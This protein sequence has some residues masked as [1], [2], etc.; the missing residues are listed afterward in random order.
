MNILISSCSK[1]VLLIKSFKTYLNNNGGLVYATDININS[2]ALYFADDYFLCPRSDNSK[3]IDFMLNNC[4]KF[5]IKLLIPTSCRELK[6]FAENKKRF[7]DIGVKVM[8]CSVTS[9]E[10]C[11]DKRKFVNFCL[12]NDIPVPKTYDNKE[13]VNTFPVFSKPITG[14]AGKGIQKI[15]NKEDLDIINFNENLVQEF[16]DWKEYTIDYLSDFEGNYINCIPRERINVVNGE[17]C[18]SQIYDNKKIKDLCKILGNKLKLIGHNTLQCF[19]NG[20]DIKFIEINPRFGGAGNLG[21]NAGLE[22][23]K[24]LIDLIYNNKFNISEPQNNLLMLRY[25]SDVFGYIENDNFI[26]QMLKQKNKI[27]CID[28]DGTLCTEMCEYKDAKP[29]VKVIKKINDLY[30]NNNKIILFTARGYTSKKDWRELT[31]KQLKEWNVK[32]HE[33]ILEKPFADYYIDNKAIDV[34]EWI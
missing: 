23:P 10:I 22:S 32:Y 16:I 21:I 26:P 5:N 9:L 7:E 13:S 20:I 12:K 31:E 27:Y 34:L 25:S 28:I 14:S 30:D 29:I 33:L 15:N 6:I 17:S 24:I 18:V 8:I 11:Q 1:K 4:K 19:C 2:P 3:F